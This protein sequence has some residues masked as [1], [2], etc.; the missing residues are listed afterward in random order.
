MEY[1]D[2][3]FEFFIFEE[4]YSNFN[5]WGRYVEVGGLTWQE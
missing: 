3:L 2:L 1:G 4:G 5:H